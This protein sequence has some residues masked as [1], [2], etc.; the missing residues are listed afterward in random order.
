MVTVMA[1]SNRL[2]E[3]LKIRQLT[4]GRSIGEIRRELVE[5]RGLRRVATGLRGLRGALQVSGYFLGD[6]CVFRG[7][8]LLELLKRTG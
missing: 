3:V 4:A 6:L 8:R 5:L 2:S 7:V 1:A